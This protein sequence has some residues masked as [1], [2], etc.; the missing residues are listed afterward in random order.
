MAC[1]SYTVAS[2]QAALARD[3]YAVVPAAAISSCCPS[4]RSTPL[5]SG[6]CGDGAPAGRERPE[7]YPFKDT[8]T[9]Y[10][11]L[12]LDTGSGRGAAP[13]AGRRLC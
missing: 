5:P 9:S 3:H 1:A 10:Y 8:L 12:V 7:V 4:S 2:L 6:T 11:D 13:A